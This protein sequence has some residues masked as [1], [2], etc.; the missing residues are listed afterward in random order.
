VPTLEQWAEIDVNGE[1]SLVGYVYSDPRN[2]EPEGAFADGHRLVTSKISVLD[3][4]AKTAQTRN[5]LYQLGE[6]LETSEIVTLENFQTLL[7]RK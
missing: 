1:Q 7:P 2:N 3:L 4:K 5:T 6:K